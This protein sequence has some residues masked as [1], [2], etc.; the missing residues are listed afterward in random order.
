MK[1][2]IIL[3]GIILFGIVS[4]TFAPSTPGMISP[5]SPKDDVSSSAT[6]IPLALPANPAAVIH[7]EDLE[8]L[9]AFRLP[10]ESGG[11]SWEYSG[12]GLTYYPLGSPNEADDGYSGSLFGVGNDQQEFVSEITIPAPVNSKN[13]DALKTAQTIQPFADIT[14]GMFGETEIPRLGIQ[15][16]PPLPGQDTGKLH[17]VH[18]QHFQYFEASH[19]WS[20]LNLGDPQPAGPWFFD[21]F[22]NY[23]T[24]DYIFEIPESWATYIPGNPRLATGRFREGVWGGSGPALFAYDPTNSGNFP[25]PNTELQQITPLLLYGI[26][27]P[28]VPEIIVDPNSSMLNYNEDDSWWGGAWLT[29]EERSAVIFVGTKALGKSWYGFANGVVWEY[30]CAEKTPP[31]CPEVPDWPYENRGYWA[32]EYKPQILFYNPA[33]LIAV[34]NGQMQTWEPQPYAV[35]DLTD[36]FINPAISLQDYKF[37]LA[38]AVAYDRERGLLYIIERLADGYKSVIHVWKIN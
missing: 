15:Y 33:D 22:T 2:R 3:S 35:L 24:S 32:E 38:G 17:F 7:P 19:G 14:G 4:C 27:E 12:H 36:T 23:V 18:G 8:Y 13:P 21:G 25:E 16:L 31:T 1:Y 28:G 34:A 5:E 26:Q 6:T 37:E 29:S 20:E 10:D 11:S 30:D 9:G